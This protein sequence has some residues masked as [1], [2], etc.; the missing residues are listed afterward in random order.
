MPR[1]PRIDL[2]GLAHHVRARGNNHARCFFRDQDCRIYLRHLSETACENGCDI[3]AF[4]LMTNHVHLLATGRR[5]GAISRMMQCLGRRYVRYV[6]DTHG[7]SGTLYEGRFKSGPVE[8]ERYFLTCMRYIELNPV[9]AGMVA[10]PQDYCWSSFAQ[11]ALGEPHEWLAPHPEYLRLGKDAAERTRAYRELFAQPF[12][13]L[14][15]AAI[16]EHTRKGRALGGD[17]FRQGLEATLGRAI[18]I[19]PLG[20][21]RKDR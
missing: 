1:S 16:R 7:R 18:G 17:T 5:Q 8:T 12:D 6:N 10:A 9:R 4:V 11:N 3:H 14:D 15:L 2:A 13:P 19:A 21:P 20:R